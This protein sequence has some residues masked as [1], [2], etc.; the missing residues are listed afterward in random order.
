MAKARIISSVEKRFHHPANRRQIFWENEQITL[1]S[2]Q[3]VGIRIAR[4]N[5]PDDNIGITARTLLRLPRPKP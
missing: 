4:C 2:K 1:G 3:S 5:Q